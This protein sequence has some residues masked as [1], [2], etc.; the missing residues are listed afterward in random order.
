[1]K[2]I[3][4]IASIFLFQACQ[5]E[6]EKPEIDEVQK[7]VTATLKLSELPRSFTYDIDGA[8]NGGAEYQWEIVF[9]INNDG[10][11][12]EGDISFMINL[13]AFDDSPQATVNRDDLE[14]YIYLYGDGVSYISTQDVEIQQISTDTSLT[15]IARSD[16]NESISLISSGTQVYVNTIY[17]DQNSGVYYYDYYPKKETYTDGLDS[18]YL[19]DGVLDFENN[20]GPVS[21]KSFPLIDIESVSVVVNET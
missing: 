11:I 13:V 1:M 10:S 2:K 12:N 20:L 5:N 16:L 9:D 15:F 21:G 3:I 7:E 18:G 4:L 8:P 14:A 17:R 6:Q 19:E